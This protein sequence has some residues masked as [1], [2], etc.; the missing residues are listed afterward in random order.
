MVCLAVLTGLALVT[1]R[2]AQ[3]H[4]DTI[5]GPVVAAA[6]AALRASDVTPVLKWIHK[7][8]EPEVRDA[9]ARTLKVRAAGGDARQLADTY[10]FETVVRLHRAGEGAPFT[11]LKPAG[12]AGD[13]AVAG[14]DRALESGSPDE[15]VRVIDGEVA[16]GIRKRF[17]RAREAR[18]SAGGSVGAGRKYVAA[19]IDLLHYVERI[20]EAGAKES[21]R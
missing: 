13:P 10:F 2:P 4:C 18:K 12:G 19:Y 14:A 5:D 17:E 21:A 9:F 3:A 6:R 15:L 7:E 20:H 8:Y 1:T 16:A 11:G